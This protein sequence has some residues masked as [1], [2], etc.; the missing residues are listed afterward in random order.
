MSVMYVH[1][2]LTAAVL[3]VAVAGSASGG[4]AAGST[5]AGAPAVPVARATEPAVSCPGATKEVSNA[6]QLTAALAAAAPGDSI[7]IAD[8]TYVG[9]FVADRAGTAEKPVF[10]CG[11]PAAVLDGDGVGGGY[12]L[13]LQGADYWRVVGF[14]VRN[15]QKGVVA[16]RSSHLVIQGLTVQDIG[17]E[18]IHLRA[19]SSDDQV[20]GNTVRRTGMRQD[21]FGEGIYVGSAV[22]NWPTYSGGEPDNSD[23]DVVRGNH[24]SD[25]TAESVDIKE[26]TTGGVVIDNTLDGAALT[27]ADSWLDAKGNG[28]LIQGNH[29][30]HSPKDGFQTHQ[31]APGWGAGNVFRANT[32]AV[33]G[34]GYGF[35][36]TPVAGN[37]LSCDN[38]ASGAASGL[39]NVPCTD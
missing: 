35:A 21:K 29:G 16:D 4:R 2:A 36:F 13:H 28:W 14:T 10:L 17:D 20:V 32:A 23:R 11:G 30:S 24:V 5:H 25:T 31:V 33:D 19:F 26:G 22:S 9:N 15:G 37:R 38:T 6:D 1:R 7:G 39:A 27:G 3:V 8:G 34:P 12:V 18:G